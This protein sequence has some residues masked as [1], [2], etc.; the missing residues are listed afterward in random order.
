[1]LK[2][3]IDRYRLRQAMK[4][5][6]ETLEELANG[7]GI[8]PTTMSK[9][10][11]SYSW[12]ASTL[13]AIASALGVPPISLLIMDEVEDDQPASPGAP[14]TPAPKASDAA[15]QTQRSRLAP[16][17]AQATPQ[18]LAAEAERRRMLLEQAKGRGG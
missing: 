4:G 17:G 12:R 6:F 7:A 3:R 9:A 10:T 16:P 11:D 1:M 18:Q 15:R 14:A 13:D 2:T 8:S 5:R